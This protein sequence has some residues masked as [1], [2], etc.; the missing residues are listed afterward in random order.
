[1][2]MKYREIRMKNPV[3][4]KS[5]AHLKRI[6]PELKRIDRAARQ[7]QGEGGKYRPVEMSPQ[8]AIGVENF[9]TLLSHFT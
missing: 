2:G 5:A 3:R 9:A 6:R 7:A 1:M 4:E 8:W